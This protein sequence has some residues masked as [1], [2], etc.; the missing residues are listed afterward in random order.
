ID[1]GEDFLRKYSG[2]KYIRSHKNLG[3]AGGNN[4]GIK[5]AKGDFLLFLNND[6]EI[7]KNFIKNMIAEFDKKPDIGILSPL[8][9]YYEAKDRVQYAGF[10]QMNYFTGR[11]KALG[12]NEVNVNQYDDKSYETAYIH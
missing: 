5:S 6:T 4:L 8:I 9:L 11:N 2:L 7:S 3:F 10:T 1:H 12:F